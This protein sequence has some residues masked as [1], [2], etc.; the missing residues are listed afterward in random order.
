MKKLS[1]I[2]SF[3]SP[4]STQKVALLQLRKKAN[5]ARNVE[6]PTPPKE[7]WIR[8][9]RRAL[10][11]SGSQLGQRLGYS[12]NKISILERR[13]QTG[14]ISLSQLKDLAEGLD[15]DF[16]YSVVPRKSVEE[17]IDDQA[18]KIAEAHADIGKQNMFLEAQ[19]LSLKAQ[20]EQ[21]ELL[22][23]KVKQQGGKVLWSNLVKRLQK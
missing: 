21:E 15:C 2:P 23:S 16:V 5:L 9:I 3:S 10:D 12:R 1:I 7:G 22:I 13:E 19:E 18:R 14:D 4:N 20:K 8:T 11:M 17:T 6:V